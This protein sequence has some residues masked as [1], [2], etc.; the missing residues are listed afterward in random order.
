M[1]NSFLYVYRR[2]M[3]KIH[4][5]KRGSCWFRCAQGD[6]A[7][8]LNPHDSFRENLW[9]FT[10]KNGDLTWFNH[11][12]IG[13]SSTKNMDF[14]DLMDEFFLGLGESVDRKTG[15]CLPPNWLEVPL[16]TFPSILGKGDIAYKKSWLGIVRSR[17]VNG[18]REKNWT[19]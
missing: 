10:I 1:F 8:R 15:W 4:P 19:C 2:G 7:P 3:V 9:F 12:K 13:I 14:M 18:D 6:L 5:Y 11:H 16:L 17:M